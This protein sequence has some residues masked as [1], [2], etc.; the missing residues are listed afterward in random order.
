MKKC[1]AILTCK[2]VQE[3]SRIA[4]EA[5]KEAQRLSFSVI[6]LKGL[7]VMTIQDRFVYV[8]LYPCLR[9]EDGI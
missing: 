8:M 5:S 9:A 2:N 4:Q 1:F 7:R 6:Y 3:S